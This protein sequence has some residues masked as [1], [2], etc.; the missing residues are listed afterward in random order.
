MGATPTALGLSIAIAVT[1]GAGCLG[2]GQSN[3]AVRLIRFPPRGRCLPRARE[4][5]RSVRR[6][7]RQRHSQGKGGDTS[8]VRSDKI[9]L[10]ERISAKM[11]QSQSMILTDF[12]G[13]TVADMTVLRARLREQSAE[14]RVIKNR[15]LKRALSEAGC[16]A[17]DECLVGN[18][19]IVFGVSDPVAPARIMVEAAEKNDKLVLKG[20]L[21]EGKRLDVAG[22]KSLSKMPGRQ[23]LLSIMAGDLKQPAAKMA[24]AF[25]AGLLKVA[26]AMNSLATKLEATETPAG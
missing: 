21:L 15:L 1:A 14:M 13:I 2:N 3:E 5:T 17:M 16:D 11:K 18:T 8:V 26:Y 10:V 25:Q 7:Y 19:A 4:P 20:G 9:D 24:M 12:N 22:V 23:E 6:L